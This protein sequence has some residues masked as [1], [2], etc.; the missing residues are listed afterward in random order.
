[1]GGSSLPKDVLVP[2]RRPVRNQSVSER[3]KELKIKSGLKNYLSTSP[4]LRVCVLWGKDKSRRDAEDPDSYNNGLND[5]ASSRFDKFFARRHQI[6]I[7]SCTISGDS[8]WRQPLENFAVY[9]ISI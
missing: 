1:M 4:L 2:W 6:Q 7:I 9:V 3:V 8:I 5:V